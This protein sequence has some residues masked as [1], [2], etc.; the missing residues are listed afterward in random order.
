MDE[1]LYKTN[2]LETMALYP[3]KKPTDKNPNKYKK[4]LAKLTDHPAKVF[5]FLPKIIIMYLFLNFS[6]FFLIFFIYF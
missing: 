3:P 4:I 1:S 6:F 5:P 2:I